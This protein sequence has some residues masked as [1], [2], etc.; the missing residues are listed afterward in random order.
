MGNVTID[1]TVQPGYTDNFTPVIELNGQGAGAGAD[2]LRIASTEADAASAVLGLI[3]N[4]FSGNG[5]AISGDGNLVAQCYIGT[6]EMGAAPGPGNG[7]H[8]VLITGDHNQ[9]DGNVIAFNGADGAAVAAGAS[10]NA[11][12]SNQYFSNAGMAIDLG[13]D[14]ATNDGEGRHY[15][16]T[17]PFET[18]ATGS[19]TFTANL[20]GASVADW[21]TATATSYVFSAETSD[22]NTSEFSPAVSAAPAATVSA[23]YVRG[24]A[25]AGPDADPLNLTFKE[26]LEAKGLGDDVFGFRADNVAADTVLPWVNLD[27]I[28]VRYSSAPTGSG[29]PTP[30]TLGVSGEKGGY[31]ITSVAPLA[32]D[33]TAYVLT[34]NKPLGGGNPATGSPP[35]PSENGDR[36]TLAV[37]GA[38]PAG[39]N[40]AL[41]MNVLQGDTDHAGEDGAHAVLARDF[42]EVKKRFFQDTNSPTL[43]PATDY[44]PF[45]DV[46]GTGAILA[47]DFAEV[48]KRF[49]QDLPAPAPA[50]PAAPAGITQSFFA[51]QPIL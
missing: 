8:G 47:N 39:S 19:A 15:A 22:T 24:S 28:V 10:G 6:D 18:N 48:K 11:L 12:A 9:L 32:G 13:D 25:W 3:I 51:T 4:G 34:L 16:E 17:Q 1:A 46:D 14:G 7:G 44:S 40:Y 38:G 27:Q 30:T 49:F 26:C 5:V 42:A 31:T 37:P 21:I 2:G 33:P 43:D 36:I 50:S 29:I 35:A 20:P 41:R 23:V 45:H